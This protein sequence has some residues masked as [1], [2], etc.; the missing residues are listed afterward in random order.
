TD[1]GDGDTGS[2]GAEGGDGDGDGDTS[3]GGKGDAGGG[4]DGSGG[5]TD[6]CETC[7]GD[8]PACKE[9]DEEKTCVE[10]TEDNLS[11]C[12]Q[13]G[14]FCSPE[15][16]CVECLDNSHCTEADASVCDLDTN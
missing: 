13:P 2:G 3:S 1:S 15:N 9:D 6:P 8:T 14:E 11:A 5:A 7:E 10:C 12:Q 4:A 16:I